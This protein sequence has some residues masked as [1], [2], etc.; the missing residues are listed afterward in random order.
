MIAQ[1]L[2][3]Q[4]PQLPAQQDVTPSAMLAI[5]VQQ[6]A[7]L[8]KLEKLMDLERQWKKDRA[9]EAYY[10]AL[11]EFKKVPI[12]VVKDKLNKQYNS[13]YAGLGNMVNTVNA[14]MAP[15][16]LNARWDIKQ[17][18][19]TITVSCILSHTLGHSEQVPMTGVPDNSGSK[20]ELQKIKS[21]ITYLESATYQA[22]TGVVA[23]DEGDDDGN[24]ATTRITEEQAADIQSL[25]DEV[26]ANKTMFL[27][28]FKIEKIEEL[29]ASAYKDAVAMLEA[30]R[31]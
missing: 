11:A 28:Y 2:A 7:D 1:A 6:N 10:Q 18:G 13:K 23:T 31:K 30:K 27:K 8:S 25:I 21:T 15:F 19:G 26:K 20:N 5:A 16:G 9:R 24:G 3:K 14:A 4:E 29:A 22:V 12:K 17:E